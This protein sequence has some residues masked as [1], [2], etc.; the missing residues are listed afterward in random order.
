LHKSGA[1]FDVEKLRWF[2]REYLLKM[3]ED[4]FASEAHHRLKEGIE[5]RGLTWSANTAHLLTQTVKERI[6]VWEDL[7]KIIFD[8]ELDF[9]FKDPVPEAKKIPDK[10]STIDD[11]RKHLGRVL[12]LVEPLKAFTSESI[13]EAVWEYANEVG[14]GSVLW[15]FRYALTGRDKSP[16]PFTVS[17]IIGKEA[18]ERRVKAAIQLLETV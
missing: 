4:D 2:N 1:I 11:T 16:D 7:E 13:K 5:G 12:E 9:F 3:R 18:T 6:S 10:K 14:R 8:G 15:P 17:A